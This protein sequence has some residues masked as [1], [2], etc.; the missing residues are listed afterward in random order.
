MEYHY[1]KRQSELDY[2]SDMRYDV[3]RTFNR[4]P[5]YDE[6]DSDRKTFWDYA[7]EGTKKRSLDDN[8]VG[9]AKRLKT[10]CTEQRDQENAK[11][12]KEFRDK[13]ERWSAILKIEES[14]EESR[15]HW[16]IYKLTN[17]FNPGRPGVCTTAIVA[18]RDEHHA[19]MIHPNRRNDWW[20]A[21][22]IQRREAWYDSRESRAYNGKRIRMPDWYVKGDKEW[23]MPAYVNVER[24]GSYEG[25]IEP[26]GK[27]LSASYTIC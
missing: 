27:V 9:K 17:K 24:L 12:D 7:P 19:R 5:A 26:D 25:E 20:S 4:L 14:I 6:Y 11:S 3:G 22:E 16:G 10:R 2:M 21:D 18:A 15:F 23:I 13:N 1:C 8:D